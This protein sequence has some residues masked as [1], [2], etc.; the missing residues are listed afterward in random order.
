MPFY[1]IGCLFGTCLIHT[2]VYKDKEVKHNIAIK[3]A[4][5]KAYKDGLN[6]VR[7]KL[8]Y[9]ETL[10]ELETE[11][12]NGELKGYGIVVFDVNELKTVNDTFHGSIK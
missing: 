9:L 4:R 5:Q 7:N 1:S 3:F 12:E 2:F 6:N 8:A 10:A 11:I